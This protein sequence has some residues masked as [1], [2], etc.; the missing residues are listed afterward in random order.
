MKGGLIS[1]LFAISVLASKAQTIPSWKLADLQQYMKTAKGPLIINV[2][3]TYCQPCVQEI[4]YFQ[5]TLKSSANV[6]VD[7]LLLSL[8]LG[9][10]YPDKISSFAKA[11][12]FYAPIAW[13]NETDA[14]VFGPTLD[15]S[16]TGAMPCS[17]FINPATGYRKFYAGQLSPDQFK[18]ALKALLN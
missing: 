7:L 1:I 11:H 5:S 6:K 18:D 17:I 2:W 8:D 10:F 15:S 16:W 9:T 4:P 12:N 14:D 3:A 13:L